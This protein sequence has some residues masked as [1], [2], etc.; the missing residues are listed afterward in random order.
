MKRI[1]LVCLLG[2]AFWSLSAWRWKHPFHTSVAEL[3]YNHKTHR[4]ELAL[5][6]FTD[7][8]EQTLSRRAGK[9]II[10]SSSRTVEPLLAD[11]LKAHV[12]LSPVRGSKSG[13]V[14]QWEMVGKELAN[15]VTWLYLESDTST[16][17][18]FSIRH[19]VLHD[20][21]E[22]QRNLLTIKGLGAE[23]SMLFTRGKAEGSF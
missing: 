8:L 7:D 20:Q 1:L 17:K 16:A 10:L 11:Y 19:S 15:D 3:Q 5:R 23:K 13:A 4:F 2:V 22:D 21:F 18:G 12:L 6:V 9:P 14:M